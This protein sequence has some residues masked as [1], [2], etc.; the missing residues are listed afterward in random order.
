MSILNEIF[1][2]C[3]RDV[4]L[5]AYIMKGKNHADITKRKW[6]I[7]ALLKEKGFKQCEIAKAF[8]VHD[9]TVLHGLREMVKM[10]KDYLKPLS[11]T[12]V[13]EIKESTPTGLK[14]EI[15]EALKKKGYTY[16]E[17]GNHFGATPHRV[18]MDIKYAKRERDFVRMK[19]RQ[20]SFTNFK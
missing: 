2:A 9:T 19:E 7:F 16:K 3:S 18:L 13:Q 15:Y 5:Y 6:E 20:K 11:D 8:N 10:G 12:I 1:E 17:I 14:I 4:Q